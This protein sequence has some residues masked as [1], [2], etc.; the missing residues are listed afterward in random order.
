VLACEI[1]T[2][3]SLLA[4]AVVINRFRELSEAHFRTRAVTLADAGLDP[5]GDHDI[6]QVVD[7]VDRA[8]RWFDLAEEGVE[9]AAGIQLTLPTATR[10]QWS[11]SGHGTLDAVTRYRAFTSPHF[12]TPH[13]DGP[14]MSALN[15]L[16][17]EQ[18]LAIVAGQLRLPAEDGGKDGW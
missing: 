18:R 1:T 4:L 6:A 7:T 13:A 12:I 2:A 8:E 16:Y 11:G 3:R 15:T 14:A 17:L 10:R 9:P 5:R